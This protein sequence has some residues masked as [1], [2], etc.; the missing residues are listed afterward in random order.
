MMKERGD[1]SWLVAKL[2]AASCPS[3][4]MNYTAFLERTARATPRK[5]AVIF[6][7][8]R[9]SY[10]EMF[11]AIGG[12]ATHLSRVCGVVK[13]QRVA[14]L[15]DNSDAYEFWYLAVLSIGAVAVP[16]NT[17]LTANEIRYQIENARVTCLVSQATFAHLLAEAGT[18]W[19]DGDSIL[20]DRRP[21]REPAWTPVAAGDAASIY[22]TSGTTGKPKGVV[23]TH[24]S[25]IAGAI[26]GPPA[27]EYDD[28][29]A[30]TLAMTPLFHIANHTWFLPVL[31]VGGTMVISAF[32]RDA[33]L[34]LIAAQRVTHVFAVPTMLLMMSARHAHTRQDLS[35][36]RTVAFGASAMPPEKLAEVQRMFPRAGLVHGMG[37]TESC[38]TIVTLPS[39][40]AFEK[41]GSVG[42]HI[43][44]MQ[45]RI[46]DESDREVA[47]G[48]VGELVARGSNVMSHYHENPEA[49][50]EALA[51]G[52]LHTGDLG[53]LDEDGFL[54]LVDRKKDLI[55]RGGENIYS[56]EVENVLYMLET[57]EQAAVVPARSELFGEEVYAFVVPR[58][59]AVID[60]ASV[61]E[62][63]SRH[64]ADYKVPVGIRVVEAMPQTATGKV[65]KHR[66]RQWLPDGMR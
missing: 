40:F 65:Q 50:S 28:V 35:H 51:G 4:G 2:E 52:W 34:D 46:V 5:T 29:G 39:S 20:F 45:V 23:H 16:L 25:L 17:R 49:T 22:Y 27:W 11:D 12:L 61:R 41:A 18:D 47:A 7:E 56:S 57:V 26:Q 24:R 62:H 1:D 59:G 6:G 31:H 63:C 9:W 8:R 37:Q 21:T 15:I 19:I 53:Y 36:V 44:G 55:I 32:G 43:G 33:V 3:A 48:V 38:G 54:F 30:V 10:S 14:L 58:P 64:L 66:L 60:E 13:G 42:V